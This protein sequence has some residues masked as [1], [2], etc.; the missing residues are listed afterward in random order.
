MRSWFKPQH[1]IK[2]M[3]IIV[4]MG[5]SSCVEYLPRMCK[6]LSVIPSIVTIAIIAKTVITKERMMI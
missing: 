4:G 1:C 3:I 2:M 5:C 6:V